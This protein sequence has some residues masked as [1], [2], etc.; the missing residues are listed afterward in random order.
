MQNDSTIVCS[1]LG[2]ILSLGDLYDARK[3]AYAGVNIFNG[4]LPE[5]SIESKDNPLQKVDYEI[6]DRISEKFHK[7][8]VNAELQ[9]S[10]LA[11][12]INLQG[13]GKY[14]QE[15]KAS[16][17]AGRMTLLYS[18]MT[19][20]ERI[21]ICNLELKKIIDLN[22]IDSFEATH[23]VVGIYWGA[24]CTITSEY[25][26]QENKKQT[27]VEGFLKAAAD[28]ISYAIK[29]EGQGN[30]DDKDNEYSKNFSFHS[31]C[32]VVTDEEL[33]STLPQTIE[34]VKKLPKLVGKSNNGKGKPLSYILLPISSV[35][36]YFNHEKQIDLVLKQL[37]E[38]SILR[39]VHLFEEISLEE[40]RYA[41]M[42]PFVFC[43]DSVDIEF[44][45]PGTFTL[46]SKV[47]LESSLSEIRERFRCQIKSYS[48]MS[49]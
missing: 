13:S 40:M 10:V 30:Y 41:Y 15:E 3:D 26:N 24:N 47:E 39:F 20:L 31:N 45:I 32:D 4:T 9:L 33:P 43:H 5:T 14:L 49:F 28:K 22:T 42:N 37:K 1:S 44:E 18:I 38:A 2:R 46:N 25:A 12:M 23:I 21:N 16:A 19:K 27:E 8:S 17:K 34:F 11:G 36:N 35:I 6:T 29:G 48:N 7:L